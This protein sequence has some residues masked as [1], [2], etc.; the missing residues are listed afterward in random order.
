MVKWYA[1]VY[2]VLTYL[3]W[4][5]YESQKSSASCSSVAEVIRR[6]REEHALR[7][8]RHACEEAIRTNSVTQAIQRFIGSE[9]KAVV[10]PELGSTKAA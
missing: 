4:Q 3:Q 1:V 9:K 7:L 5:L 10:E 6:H 2:L 8:L